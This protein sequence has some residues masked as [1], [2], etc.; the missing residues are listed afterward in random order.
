MLLQCLIKRYS[1]LAVTQ[2]LIGTY[3]VCC[4][5]VC[6]AF[7]LLA[8]RSKGADSFMPQLMF[9][10]VDV[11]GFKWEDHDACV[12]EF[13]LAFQGTRLGIKSGL[14]L[15]REFDRSSFVNVWV[16]P[17]A[18]AVTI[19]DGMPS[20]YSGMSERITRQVL[21]LLR[22]CNVPKPN[23]FAVSERAWFESAVKCAATLNENS[24]TG[25]KSFDAKLKRRKR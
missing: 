8:E 13:K 1:D 9:C 22:C 14:S 5:R 18:N 23:Y 15:S 11:D 21:G 12:Q 4:A 16:L 20:N 17:R 24:T 2:R 7:D 10:S 3:G 6:L 19:D 25:K